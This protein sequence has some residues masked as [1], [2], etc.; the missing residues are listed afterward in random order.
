MCALQS[1][2]GPLQMKLSLHPKFSLQKR[3][4]AKLVL[5]YSILR[6][7]HRT[8]VISVGFIKS[9]TH[10]SLT[11]SRYSDEEYHCII[12]LLLNERMLW[13]PNVTW[14]HLVSF[15]LIKKFFGEQLT[16][17]LIISCDRFHF[18]NGWFW[19]KLLYF[20]VNKHKFL[21]NFPCDFFM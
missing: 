12:A 21:I 6:G 19:C 7:L 15:Y 10:S 4:W 5:H 9:I 13:W 1:I 18:V 17:L 2:V 14:C 11:T 16:K 8:A 3:Q 20:T